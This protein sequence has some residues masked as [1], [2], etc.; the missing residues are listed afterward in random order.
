MLE[1]ADHDARV[2]AELGGAALDSLAGE[3]LF[4]G[5]GEIEDF[6]GLEPLA[7]EGIGGLFLFALSLVAELV[8]NCVAFL[9]D[10]AEDDMREFVCHREPEIVVA[11][12]AAR[13]DD[14]GIGFHEEGGSISGEVGKLCFLAV[15]VALGKESRD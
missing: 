15:M 9:A 13:P 4:V 14:E 7:G 2:K 5:L 12:E 8:Q 6:L 10:V 3:A 1:P 11:I